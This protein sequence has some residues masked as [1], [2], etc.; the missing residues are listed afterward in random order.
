MILKI[1]R[2]VEGPFEMEETMCYNLCLVEYPN[3]YTANEEIIYESF[4][5]AY[6]DIKK[7][8][9]TIDPIEIEFDV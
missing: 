2:I 9:T 8:S 1:H 3:G 5:E 6:E 7:L 4:D